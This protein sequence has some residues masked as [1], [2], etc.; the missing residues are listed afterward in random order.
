MEKKR[1][2]I[3]LFGSLPPPI[4]G[5]SISFD[6]LVT[7]LNRHEDIEP[8]V[9]N[10]SWDRT[11]G[12]K[13]LFRLI[14][15]L[16]DICTATVRADVVSLHVCTSS[17]PSLGLFVLCLTRLCRK[18]FIL[19]KFGGTNYWERGNFFGSLSHFVVRHA[20][21]YLAQT[22][23]LVNL[24]AGTG[25]SHVEWYPTSRPMQISSVQV[26]LQPKSCRRFVFL[27][28][29]K[30]TKGIMEIIRAGER[31]CEND[32][33]AVD[34]F[35]PMDF[36]IAEDVFF[37]LKKVRY[38]GVVKSDNVDQMLSRYDAL[39][40]PSYHPGEGYPGVVLEAY[41]AGLPVICTRWQA[42][43][44]IVNENSGILIEPKNSDALYAAMK[45]LVGDD[46]TY[47]RLRVGVSGTRGAFSSEYWTG[48]FVN[49]C[50][51]LSEKKV[52]IL[53]KVM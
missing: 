51:K 34:V 32:E 23:Q 27:G 24:A 33:I 39:L 15:V 7:F 50:R 40:L 19:R 53:A 5:T 2:R 3:A 12:I 6:H 10:T 28:Q 26:T 41:G 20:D 47:S 46:E 42:L 1:L 14:T 37:G 25:I 8:L 30:K 38:C 49:L 52:K 45:S 31:F 22:V 9:V 17:L 29:I 44:E 43:P 16:R 35:G 18:P 48:Y 36:D 4:G 13:G 11:Q 21:L